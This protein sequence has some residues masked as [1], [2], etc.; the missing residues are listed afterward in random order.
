M[1]DK[2]GD[3]IVNDGPIYAMI[4]GFTFW[5]H[6]ENK[7]LFYEQFT[8]ENI[9]RIEQAI[10]TICMEN[11][12]HNQHV[13]NFKND[14]KIDWYKTLKKTECEPCMKTSSNGN[15]FPRYWPFVRWIHRSPVMASQITSLTIVYPTVYLGADQRK[16]QTSVSLAFVRGIHRWSVNSMHKWPVTR[17]MFPFYGVILMTEQNKKGYILLGVTV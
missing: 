1:T 16:H 17:K 2:S 13:S 4:I 9:H 11:V 7:G 15:I 12:V 3:L 6:I 8:G 10:C 14:R 5:K